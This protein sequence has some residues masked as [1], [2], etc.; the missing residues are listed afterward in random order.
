MEPSSSRQTNFVYSDLRAL[1]WVLWLTGSMRLFRDGNG[2]SAVMRPWHPLTWVLLILAI[3][4]CA[5]MGVKLTEAVPLTL[6]RFWKLNRQHLY[7][8]TPW[9]D[10]NTLPKRSGPWVSATL[11][12]D[13]CS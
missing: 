3:L 8:V 12:G 2:V 4:P 13:E 9:T 10:L 5:I 6:S 7:W 11:Y 1:S